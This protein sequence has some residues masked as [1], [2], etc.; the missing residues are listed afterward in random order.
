VVTETAAF[1]EDAPTVWRDALHRGLS[2]F[3]QRTQER[4]FPSSL[5][6]A[7]PDAERLGLA[8]ASMLRPRKAPLIVTVDAMLASAASQRGLP[9]INPLWLL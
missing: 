4:L 3:V 9:V 2:F 7:D 5:L 8:D 6:L 1:V